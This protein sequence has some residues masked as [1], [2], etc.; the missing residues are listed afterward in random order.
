[1]C[2]QQRY[3]VMLWWMLLCGCNVARCGEP[4]VHLV[5]SVWGNFFMAKNTTFSS[6]DTFMVVPTNSQCTCKRQCQA[7]MRCQAWSFVEN[8]DGR[9]ECRLADRG[10]NGYS[11]TYNTTA[12]Y[13]FRQDSVNGTYS[14]EKDGLLYLRARVQRIFANAKAF[15][16]AIPGHRLVIFKTLQQKDILLA[17][18]VN[19]KFWV[20]DLQKNGTGAIWGD[21]TQYG[22]TELGL[23][24]PLVTDQSPN[25][26]VYVRYNSRLD[27][28]FNNYQVNVLCQANPLGLN[29]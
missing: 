2:G 1:M 7:I 14:L 20:V 11:T 3:V 23:N 8:S 15:C 18:P 6:A 22:D 26:S 12:T 28:F 13:Y 29:W 9:R 17:L 4:S 19:D 25:V 5:E 10:P 21:G 16:A 27:D 24:F